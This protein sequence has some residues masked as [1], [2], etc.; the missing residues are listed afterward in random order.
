MTSRLQPVLA[1]SWL[2][3]VVL[4]GGILVAGREVLIPLALAIVIWQLVNAIARLYRRVRI[5]GQT[6]PRWARFVLALVT[7]ALGLYLAIDVI[8]S[9]VAQVSQAAGAYEESLQRMLA[10]LRARFD[11]TAAPPASRLLEGIDIGGLVAR[12][13]SALGTLAGNI[14]LVLLYVVFLLFEQESFDRKIDALFPEPGRAAEVRRVL[15]D[16]EDRIARYL[17]IKTL[18]SVATAALSWAVLKPVGVTFAE[19]WALIVFLLNFIPTIGS[20][21]AVL[22]PTLLTLLQFADAGPVLIVLAGLGSVQFVLGNLLEPRLMGSS[23]NLSPMVM[24]VSLALWG[25]LWGVAGMFLCVPIT[26]MVMIVCAEFPA[27]RP[28]AVLLSSTGRVD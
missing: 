23:L 11:I 2:V 21:F 19:F 27:T 22:L 15:S 18:L 5:R 25:S 16:I 9:N 13:S 17:W 7:I 1:A 28:L 14:G 26:V 10:A 12:L 20:I 6:A 24:I 3:I 8:A 4:L